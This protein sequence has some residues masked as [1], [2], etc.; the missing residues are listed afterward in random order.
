VD[1]IT[2]T[3]DT[4]AA[5]CISKE[6]RIAT[7][8]RRIAR[9]E[10]TPSRSVKQIHSWHVR[11]QYSPTTCLLK[12]SWYAELPSVLS[13]NIHGYIENLNTELLA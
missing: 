9:P 6:R 12:A 3:K 2:D 5:V 7:K 4:I 11:E 1:A 8:E 13:D 10:A